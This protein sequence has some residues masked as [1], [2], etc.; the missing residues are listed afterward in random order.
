MPPRALTRMGA[1]AEVDSVKAARDP[2]T[3]RKEP[4]RW[5]IFGKAYDLTPFLD[6]HPGGRRILMTCAGELDR[7]VACAALA[8]A[9]QQGYRRAGAQRVLLASAATALRRGPPS[10]G[11]KCIKHYELVG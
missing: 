6:Q 11:E 4:L 2:P 7:C 1:G 10:A 9:G 8:R 5:N 3:A